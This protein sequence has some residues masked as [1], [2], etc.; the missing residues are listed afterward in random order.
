MSDDKMFALEYADAFT[1]ILSSAEQAA[2]DCGCHGKLHA[3]G[4]HN[5]M[6]ST[7]H[8]G[9]IGDAPQSTEEWAERFRKAWNAGFTGTKSNSYTQID[10]KPVYTEAEI[11]H[12]KALG[13]AIG[14]LHEL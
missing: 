8:G 6:E 5:A 10:T 13:N 4:C 9:I 12:G 11:A 14:R 7:P 2:V 3:R 1:D